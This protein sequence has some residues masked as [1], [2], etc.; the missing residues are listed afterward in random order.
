VNTARDLTKADETVMVDLREPAD[1]ARGH[2]R[3]A[4]SVPFSAKGLSQRLAVVV[5]PGAQIKL[6][7][8][9]P[10]VA[11]AALEQLR[12]AYRVIGVIDGNAWRQAGVLEDALPDIPIE[13]LAESA[14]S[15]DLAIVDVREPVEWE[16][17]CAPGAVL[18]PLGS[19][20]ERMQSVPHD[21]LVAVICESGVRSSTGASLLQAA[22]FTT[23]ATVS[24]GMSGY[25]RAGLPL[26][27]PES[28]GQN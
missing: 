17:G 1:F 21:A 27:F 2:P 15:G 22:G 16:T 23:V 13:R 28:P 5:E 18:I 7:A 26:V 3:G 14:A 6:L 11:S 20:R 12:D 24:A 8:S 9:E 4:V 10:A 25:R 19:L